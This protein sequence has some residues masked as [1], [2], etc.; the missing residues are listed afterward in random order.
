M[1]K[2]DLHIL[3]YFSAAKLLFY[4]QITESV[5]KFILLIT[6]S[7]HQN[8][9]RLWRQNRGGRGGWLRETAPSVAALN[10]GS[11]PA[12]PVYGWPSGSPPG[13]LPCGSS[14]GLVIWC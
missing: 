12:G 2:F 1:S 7:V 5:I 4:F 8:R 10:G 6:P 13:I 11:A 9:D 3:L 14:G